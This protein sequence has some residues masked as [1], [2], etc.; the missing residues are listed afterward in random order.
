[1]FLIWHPW[2][3][4]SS[5][6]IKGLTHER[7][8]RSHFPIPND[9]AEAIFPWEWRHWIFRGKVIRYRTSRSVAWIWPKSVLN[10]VASLFPLQ[11]WWFQS[12]SNATNAL[13]TKFTKN[14][15]WQLPYPFTFTGTP[16]RAEQNWNT[17]KGN[18]ALPLSVL[19]YLGIS[20]QQVK[21]WWQHM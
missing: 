20:T 16:S 7:E 5:L 18:L 17:F 21:V 12:S 1:M 15:V 6:N 13:L 4:Q 3:L 11:Y 9:W 19:W 2:I 10:I 14:G 8:K